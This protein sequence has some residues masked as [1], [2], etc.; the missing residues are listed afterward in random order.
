VE[1]RYRNAGEFLS[2]LKNWRDSVVEVLPTRLR[3]NSNS[4]L[5][6]KDYS[7]KTQG[8]GFDLIAGMYELK[9]TLYQ[10]IIRPLSEP[11]LYKEYGV[12]PPNGMLLYGPPGCGKTYIAQKLAEE[13]GYHYIEVKPSDLASIYIHGTREKIGKMF[14]EAE[15]KAP[16][17]IFIDEVDA[18]LPSRD[19]RID[20]HVSS[21]V[22]EFLAQM[23]NCADKGIF[24]VAATNR[25]ENIDPAIMRTG[26]IDK[27]VYLSPPDILARQ[28]MMRL[29]LR[30]RPVSADIDLTNLAGL[31]D[32]Y[33]SSDIKFLVNEASRLALKDRVKISNVQFE[34]VL[35]QHHPSITREQVR[36]YEK[37]REK[38]TFSSEE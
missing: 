24:I 33:V 34:A 3:D 32:G 31:M 20:Q 6:D 5:P 1:K 2:A 38:R 23:T 11:E 13:I 14:K 7:A 10:D 17:L 19:G 27:V 8:K 22:N 30:N 21:E 37:F 36:S 28:E 9:E 25:P 15:V 12:S 4:E 16:T 29:Y 26:R 18:V 35:K